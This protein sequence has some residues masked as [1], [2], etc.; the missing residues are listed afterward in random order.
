MTKKTTQFSAALV[1]V[2]FLLGGC[3]A[4][5]RDTSSSQAESNSTESQPE[6]IAEPETT[7]EQ[8]QEKMAGTCNVIPE[9][10]AP[11]RVKTPFD[12]NLLSD[13]EVTGKIVRITTEKGEIVFELLPEEGPCA[14]SNF[15]TLVKQG[16]YDG[17]NFHRVEP[18]FVIQ[19]GDPNGN[20]TGGPGYRFDD[21]AVKLDYNKGIVAMANRGPNTNGSQFFIMLSDYPLPPQYT[22]FGRVLEGQ[23]VVNSIVV[24]DVMETVVLED[25]E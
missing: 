16:F 22:I 3:G 7:M 18:G 13:E 19:G 15:V 2:V 20:G 11:D 23:D 1:A 24:G 25:A 6:Q 9:P 12:G 5:T 14:V 8:P 21:D 17:L 4:P 10:P